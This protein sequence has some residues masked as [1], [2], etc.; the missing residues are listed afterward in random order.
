MD[1]TLKFSEPLP[2]Q[3]LSGEKDTTWRINDD[4]DICLEDKLILLR[5]KDL[6]QFGEAEVLW[7]KYTRFGNL[8]YEDKIGHEKFY[9][10]E[11]MY[12]TY[13]RYYNMKVTPDTELKVI[14]FRL[15]S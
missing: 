1:K 3:V 8:T 9:S 2:G 6:S 14:K 5:K 15:L 11:Q 13:S 10:E 12:A 4:K 7:V